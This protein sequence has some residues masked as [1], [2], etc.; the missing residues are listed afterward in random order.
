MKFEL[1]KDEEKMICDWET[2][3]KCNARGKSCCGGEITYSFTPTSIGTAVVV[4]CICG[5]TLTVREL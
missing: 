2:N 5:E 4:Q 1:S 3:H